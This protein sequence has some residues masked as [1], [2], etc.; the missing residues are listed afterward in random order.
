MAESLTRPYI[1]DFMDSMTEE[2][3]INSEFISVK[4]EKDSRVKDHT[5]KETKLGE[6]YGAFIMYVKRGEK[7]LNS[8][9][10]ETKIEDGDVLTM[11]VPKEY[12]KEILEYLGTA[13]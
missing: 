10:A 1:I 5:I 3:D 11:R 13:K 8:P 9:R 4:I 12:E 7:Y 6:A 2:G